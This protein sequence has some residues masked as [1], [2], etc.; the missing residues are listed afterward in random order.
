M[1]KGVDTVN[2]NDIVAA[3]AN[4]KTPTI[5][6]DFGT[7]NMAPKPIE[8]LTI[9]VEAGDVLTEFEDDHSVEAAT[10]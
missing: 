10:R 9:K 3:P 5:A 8:K 2:C 4:I 6:K 1:L 7:M